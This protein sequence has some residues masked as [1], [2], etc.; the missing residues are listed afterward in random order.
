MAVRS[1][2]MVFNFEHKQV[3][4]PLRHSCNWHCSWSSRSFE[5]W[6]N[7]FSKHIQILRDVLSLVVGLR[8]SSVMVPI[9]LILNSRSV[10]LQVTYSGFII[11]PL[12]SVSRKSFG[13]FPVPS[14]KLRRS[15][16]SIKDIIL[17][18]HSCINFME[19]QIFPF[20]EGAFGD[21]QI[22]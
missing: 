22:G 6:A 21:N 7:V 11:S 12:S 18:F 1:S 8:T 13:S 17:V 15:C 16:A 10:L 19:N 2:H 20:G 5:D 4:N 9:I 14:T 3:W